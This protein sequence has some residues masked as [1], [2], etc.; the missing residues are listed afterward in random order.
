VYPYKKPCE[1]PQTQDNN[2]LEFNPIKNVTKNDADSPL[3]KFI[4]FFDR[5]F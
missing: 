4:N 3:E 5:F 2:F 1:I